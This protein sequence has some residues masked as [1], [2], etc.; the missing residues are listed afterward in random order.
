MKEDLL[1][2]I[3]SHQKLKPSKLFTTDGLPVIIFRA[4]SHNHYSGPDFFNARIEIGGQLWAGNVELHVKASDWYQHR[5]DSDSRYNNVILHVVWAY[6]RP[7]YTQN[8][9]EIPAVELRRLIPQ[10]LL[11]NYTELFKARKTFINCERRINEVPDFMVTHW[12]ERMF[13]ERL[14]ERTKGI[15]E[16]LEHCNG[17][18]EELFFRYLFKAMGTKVN[19][20]YFYDLAR[21]LRLTL[22]RKVLVSGESLE[23]LLYGQA[24]MLDS[25]HGESQYRRLQSEYRFLY[26]KYNLKK[27]P[28]HAPE[29]FGLRPDNFPTIRLSQ[30]AAMFRENQQLF[31][32]VIRNK[33][34]EKVRDSLFVQGSFYWN[35]HYVFGKSTR[36]KY[37]KKL[38]RDTIDLLIINTVIPVKYAFYVQRGDDASGMISEMSATIRAERNSIIQSFNR[39]GVKTDSSLESQGLLQLYHNYCNRNKCLQ[40]AVGSKIISG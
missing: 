1:H 25:E 12:L 24:N 7:V 38:S 23:A 13:F 20:G 5:H 17:D 16:E 14:E 18:W 27:L 15:Y 2:Y 26:R 22:I 33:D 8:G 9:S 39:L 32:S 34:L 37:P 31:D 19:A 3:W 35:D 6:D 11:R 29:Y 40:C 21:S 4:G 30:L 36:R 10:T 28:F